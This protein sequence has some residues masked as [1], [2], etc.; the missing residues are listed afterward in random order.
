MG[1]CSSKKCVG[2]RSCG[3]GGRVKRKEVK[4]REVRREEE[5]QEERENLRIDCDVRGDSCSGS[6]TQ[7][8]S[9]N[10]S[11]VDEEFYGETVED[12]ST[13][14]TLI[15]THV[16]MRGKVVKGNS[17]SGTK[18]VNQYEILDEL[19]EG[20]YG[21]VKLVLN[22]QTGRLYAM[23]IIDK[24]KLSKMTWC[25]RSALDNIRREIS[26]LQRLLHPNI[27][28]LHEV[29]D[30]DSH[31]KLY[32]ITDYC[33]K[34]AIVRLD[35]F[36][37]RIITEREEEADDDIDLSG[38]DLLSEELITGMGS[39][40]KNNLTIPV[41]GPV[42]P[43]SG[44]SF[45]S[46][47]SEENSEGKMEQDLD[48]G[49]YPHEG[50]TRTEAQLATTAVSSPRAAAPDDDP[51][52][53]V[54]PPT[55]APTRRVSGNNHLT[56]TGSGSGSR[57]VSPATSWSKKV[58]SAPTASISDVIYAVSQALRYCHSQGVVHRDLKPGNVFV[59]DIGQVKLGDFGAA[60][61]FGEDGEPIDSGEPAAKKKPFL[62]SP[63][64]SARRS[65]TPPPPMT[66]LKGALGSPPPSPISPGVVS[67]EYSLSK[68]ERNFFVLGN[69][70]QIEGT[71]AFW[72]PELCAS[73]E[74]TLK[75]TLQL[76]SMGD[77][78]QLGV[79][80]HYLLLRHLPFEA[81]SHAAL[82]DLIKNKPIDVS[83]SL[84]QPLADAVRGL[85]RRDTVQRMNMDDLM[86][87]TNFWDALQTYSDKLGL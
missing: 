59:D 45:H 20:G 74:G 49:T 63:Y 11:T 23:K 64:L 55:P 41:L 35:Q 34:G 17:L 50:S 26:I 7:S 65:V 37:G 84:P 4:T 57:P 53:L 10:S 22:T 19:G 28:T 51:I 29:I 70:R 76:Y 39:F 82:K 40:G 66:P 31:H 79:L 47:G 13:D 44:G 9:R 72:P 56:A 16:V 14:G 38:F 32:M 5:A 73:K 86:G 43:P 87:T 77:C 78:W 15:D 52:I 58:S 71:P 67:I 62:E 42:P 12:S 54:E 24:I 85:L 46:S 75:P 2:A 27:I 80:L 36:T 1:A 68:K 48:T 8:E 25:G 33:S 81:E 61:L 30:D 60:I 18:M 83:D 69:F 3:C 6:N 21:K